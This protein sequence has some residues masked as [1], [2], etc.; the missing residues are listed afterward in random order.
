MDG[1]GV[2]RKKQVCPGLLMCFQPGPVQ[3]LSMHAH[4]AE[5][6]ILYS[7]Q[8]ACAGLD[9]RANNPMISTT[10]SMAFS[11]ASRSSSQSKSWHCYQQITYELRQRDCEG[12]RNWSGPLRQ[13]HLR[14]TVRA[15]DSGH[16]SVLATRKPKYLYRF[17][18]LFLARS[19]ERKSIR[20]LP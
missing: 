13:N 11:L 1:P 20:P 7:S 15:R 16:Q 10:R 17:S 19:A 3:S 12:S 8:T 18:V 5:L 14:D 2:I 6:P 4:H 9:V